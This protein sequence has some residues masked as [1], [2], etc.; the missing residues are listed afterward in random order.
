MPPRIASLVPSLTELCFDLDLGENLV[1]RTDYCISPAGRVEAVPSVGGPKTVNRVGL[2]AARPS[3]VLVSPEENPPD[4]AEA[5]SACG[6]EAVVVHPLA[7]EDNF[8]LFL[9]F[10]ATFDRRD[11]AE[12]LCGRLTTALAKADA[13]RDAT[14]TLSVLPLVWRDPWVTVSRRTYA[15]AMLAA[16]GMECVATG[17]ALYPRIA[18]LGDAARAADWIL[19]TTEPYAFTEADIS[20]LKAELGRNTVTLVDG[21]AVA[22]Y[23]SRA[24]A[25]L[26]VLASLKRR[27][28]D[29]GS[30]AS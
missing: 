10:G 5:I 9:R 30:A 2:L 23:G 15:A 11:Q 20:R 12:V 22:W 25:A 29:I 14:P 13:V 28:L 4:I 18:D 26:P 6:A 16:V 3:H 8:E 19:P 17:E 7:P 1:C 24:I 27:L 21:E